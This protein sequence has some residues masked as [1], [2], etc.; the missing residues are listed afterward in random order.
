M[1]RVLLMEGFLCL[2]HSIITD[3]DCLL[4]EGVVTDEDITSLIKHIADTPEETKELLRILRKD[5]DLVDTVDAGNATDGVNAD[6]TF[7][8]GDAV[9]GA[10]SI[11]T[12]QLNLPKSKCVTYKGLFDALYNSS[13]KKRDVL[14]SYCLINKGQFVQQPFVFRV[15]R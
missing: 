1:Q 7:D 10:P 15:M 12:I 13:F 4:K 11:T 9:D 3:V 5:E 8:G 2:C 14:A 6:D